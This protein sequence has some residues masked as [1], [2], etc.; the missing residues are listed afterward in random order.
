MLRQSLAAARAARNR[1]MIGRAL[2]NPQFEL[3]VRAAGRAPELLT[4][5]A[6]SSIGHIAP[7]VLDLA[8][9][10]AACAVKSGVAESPATL[11][12]IDY[13]RPS[14]EKRLWVYDL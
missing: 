1:D 10:A 6:F 5:G 4:R 9:G 13:S 8:L 2:F 7:P 14:T 3:F 12:V 11:T